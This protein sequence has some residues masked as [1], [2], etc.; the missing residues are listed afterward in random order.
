MRFLALLLAVTFPVQLPMPA[1]EPC[2]YH[3]QAPSYPRLARQT[4]IQGKVTVTV[5]VYRDGTTNVSKEGKGHPLLVGAAQEN[6]RTWKF[7]SNDSVEPILLEVEYQFIL[8]TQNSTD[9]VNA[10]SAVTLDLPRHVTVVAPARKP[11][12]DVT[13]VNKKHW[14]QF[15]K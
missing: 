11:I 15:W 6:L 14:C 12:I 4:V 1:P 7:K 10:T 8:D 13:V 5:T 3:L 2:V 9:D